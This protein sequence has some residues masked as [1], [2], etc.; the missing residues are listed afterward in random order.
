ML[1]QV[2]IVQGIVKADHP[3]RRAGIF[4]VQGMGR[5]GIKIEGAVGQAH[6]VQAVGIAGAVELLDH[7]TGGRAGRSPLPHAAHESRLATAG[8]CLDETRT[9]AGLRG[10][11]G[12]PAGETGGRECTEEEI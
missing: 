5:G 2:V 4:A 10:G 3:F 11:L 8:S 7:R 1:F 9:G 12:K 6:T